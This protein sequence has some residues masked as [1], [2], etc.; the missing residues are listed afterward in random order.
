MT[1]S[2]MIAAALLLSTPACAEPDPRPTDIVP[3]IA[4]G[5]RAHLLDP[6]SATGLTV[7][8]PS[9][10]DG[11]HGTHRGWSVLFSVNAR[12]TYG[13]YVG[14]TPGRAYFV[15]GQLSRISIDPVSMRTSLDADMARLTRQLLDR[16]ER[17]P[18]TDLRRL[19][20]G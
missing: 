20:S 12:N 10:T 2:I 3:Q 15:N 14:Q 7:C 19:I 9:Y 6:A 16:C 1:R 17:I 13:G 18:E 5:L 8:H 4:I 11:Q